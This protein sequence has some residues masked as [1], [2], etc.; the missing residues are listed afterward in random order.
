M[1]NQNCLF[2]LQIQFILLLQFTLITTSFSQEN[3]SFG[4]P[5]IRLDTIEAQ[6]LRKLTSDDIRFLRV[7]VDDANRRLEDKGLKAAFDNQFSE[8]VNEVNEAYRLRDYRRYFVMANR[9]LQLFN[10]KAVNEGSE[11]ASSLQIG[12]NARL[13]TAPQTLKISLEPLYKFPLNEG[14]YTAKISLISKDEENAV[15]ELKT[16]TIDELKY[17]SH[18]LGTVGLKKGSYE[19]QYDLMDKNERKIIDGVTYKFQITESLDNKLAKL[20]RDLYYLRERK[21][22]SVGIPHRFCLQAIEYNYQYLDRASKQYIGNNQE[23]EFPMVIQNRGNINLNSQFIDYKG[24]ITLSEEMIEDLIREKNP[25]ESLKGEI[26]LAYLDKKTN[27]LL[28]FSVYIPERY[29]SDKSFP[30]VVAL[31]HEGGDE[32]SLYN[33]FIDP[34]SSEKL[35]KKYADERNF[36]LLFPKDRDVFSGYEGQSAVDVMEIAVWM[37]KIYPIN[38]ERIF[39]MGY[40]SGGGAVIRLGFRNY[41]Y[42]AGL[43][44]I[45]RGVDEF[46]SFKGIPERALGLPL[47]IYITGKENDMISQKSESSV[48]TMKELLSSFTYT[49]FIEEEEKRAM[50]VTIQNIFDFFTVT[51]KK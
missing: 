25:L 37:Q 36:I 28:P 1:K 35:L 30:M 18:L 34:V 22:E 31:H 39:L 2:L 27:A 47:K 11:V 38:A 43:A 46:M 13:L 45:N 17:F 19:I 42:F 6:F 10:G 20:K 41:S 26:R 15:T 16:F 29:K 49:K 5:L 24:I 3:G 50:V 51:R 32:S 8:L 48:K 21:T 7:I 9:F 33:A 23:I 40:G 4:A 44:T 14:P 12:L